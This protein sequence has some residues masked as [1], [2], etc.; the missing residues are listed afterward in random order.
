LSSQVYKPTTERLTDA[1]A[2]YLRCQG[3]VVQVSHRH[4]ERRDIRN[5]HP[6]EPDHTVVQEN[7]FD[8]IPGCTT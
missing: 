8:D 2:A 3:N 6:D 5:G 1:F 7:Q 4:V